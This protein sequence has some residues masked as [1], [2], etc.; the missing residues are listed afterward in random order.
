M[1]RYLLT[2]N[3]KWDNV[4]AFIDRTVVDGVEAYPPV[5][6][7]MVDLPNY[8]TQIA[9]AD[10]INTIF[11]TFGEYPVECNVMAVRKIYLGGN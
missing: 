7:I 4:P 9:T 11:D 2:L 6:R 10:I 3:V 5:I 1:T 8:T